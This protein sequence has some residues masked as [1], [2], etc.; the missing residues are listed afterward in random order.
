ME[1]FSAPVFLLVRRIT[2][3]LRRMGDQHARGRARSR[4]RGSASRFVFSKPWRRSAHPSPRSC[5]CVVSRVYGD[6]AAVS[7]P[8]PVPVLERRVSCS[9]R[10]GGVQHT[11]ARARAS[12]SC[13]LF[14]KAYRRSAP[15]C[16]CSYSY[17]CVVL[18]VIGG[19]VWQR[20]VPVPVRC[21]SSFRRRGCDHHA[22]GRARAS[23]FVFLE[24][25][26][27]SPRPCPCPCI[28]F[29]VF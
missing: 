12:A 25:W 14:T 28:A 5:L 6:V 3:F 20:P 19:V 29:R 27:R 4:A 24:A 9:R 7:T 1:A 18:R 22:R 26:L 16:L 13:H 8:V 11:Q 17:S 10:R 15:P 2:C 23:R 21:V